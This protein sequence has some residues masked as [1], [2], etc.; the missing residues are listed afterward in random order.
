MLFQLDGKKSLFGVLLMFEL[1][2]QYLHT[3]KN[4]AE[5]MNL[6]TTT[7]QDVNTASHELTL[8]IEHIEYA[9]FRFEKAKRE[10]Q[11]RLRK[12][13]LKK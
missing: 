6:D 8:C 13:V 11:E 2:E 10:Y 7:V 9:I 4:E 3:A 12:S 5:L 1:L